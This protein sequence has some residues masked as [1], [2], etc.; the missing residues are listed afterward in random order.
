MP[1]DVNEGA[2]GDALLRVTLELS[3][4]ELLKYEWIEEGK[5]Y[6]EWL[7]PNWE[8]S[9]GE[10]WSRRVPPPKGASP[11][12]GASAGV[13]MPLGFLSGRGFVDLH[14]AAARLQEVFFFIRPCGP[15]RYHRTSICRSS[16]LQGEDGPENHLCLC[17][18]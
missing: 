14:P 16:L 11:T 6:R 18:P 13:P 2:K 12:R 10:D 9:S 15:D 7:I 1:L 17:T 4:E 8:G 3:G 5:P